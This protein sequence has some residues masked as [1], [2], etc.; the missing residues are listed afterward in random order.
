MLSAQTAS[1]VHR[2]RTLKAGWAARDVIV[3]SAP[4]GPGTSVTP[5][6][7]QAAAPVQET[8]GNCKTGRMDAELRKI[9]GGIGPRLRDLRRSRGLT[10]EALAAGT[11]ISVSTLSRLEPGRR[12]PTLDLLIPLARAHSVA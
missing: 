12:R 2:W 7:G 4:S 9:L 6:S 5:C 10:L 11:A 8:C 1:T 3:S